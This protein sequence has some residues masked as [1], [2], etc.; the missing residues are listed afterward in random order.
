MSSL[1]GWPSLLGCR[2]LGY[3]VGT[4]GS[5]RG[6]PSAPEPDLKPHTTGQP[7]GTA[8]MDGFMGSPAMSLLQNLA[9]ATSNAQDTTVLP[10]ALFAGCAM[11]LFF[12]L[13]E[14]V[15]DFGAGGDG[16]RF[17]RVREAR[18]EE[19]RV[20]LNDERQSNRDRSTPSLRLP[21]EQAQLAGAKNRAILRY[22]PRP[23]NSQSLRP[24][25]HLARFSHA[26]LSLQ[27]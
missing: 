25:P 4:R 7:C 24:L 1:M 2:Q 5:V 26:T 21:P 17:F 18:R 12:R 15:H 19:Y 20:Y 11:D 27:S 16:K 6:A 3:E 9:Q 8:G 10:G 14:P 13:L 22:R 23:W